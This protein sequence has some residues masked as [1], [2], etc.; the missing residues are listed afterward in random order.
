MVRRL[1]SIHF[2]FR[3]RVRNVIK[4]RPFMVGDFSQRIGSHSPSWQHFESGM[5]AMRVIFVNG[6][7]ALFCPKALR[8]VIRKSQS[9]DILGSLTCLTLGN[10]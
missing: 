4:K 3:E 1:L 5:N 8:R 6:G 9:M 10:S 7:L 2:T